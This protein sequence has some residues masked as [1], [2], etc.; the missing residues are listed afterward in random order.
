MWLSSLRPPLQSA[1]ICGIIYLTGMIA[2]DLET[3]RTIGHNLVH[4]GY[5]TSHW[6]PEGYVSGDF[7]P[8]EGEK[9]VLLEQ[10]LSL[11]LRL[12]SARA[13]RSLGSSFQSP[14]LMPALPKER[15]FISP[16]ICYSPLISNGTCLHFVG[17]WHVFRLWW[18]GLR[19]LQ[20]AAQ[21]SYL[22]CKPGL[23]PSDRC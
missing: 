5:N 22:V 3:Q 6:V 12:Y 7:L 10:H 18:P 4:S 2:I 8:L 17:P 15:C 14:L 23:A 16:G 13:P 21:P 9:W 11:S 20:G 19:L 1:R